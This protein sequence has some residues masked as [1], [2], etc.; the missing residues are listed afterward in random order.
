MPFLHKNCSLCISKL[1][2]LPLTDG[3]ELGGL[4]TSVK[5]DSVD[6]GGLSCRGKSYKENHCLYP[7]DLYPFTRRPMFIIIDSDNSFVF[8][9]IP[10]YFG[11]P[12][13]ILMSPQDVPP[14]FQGMPQ[15]ILHYLYLLITLHFLYQ[16]MCNIMA[17]CSH[18]SCTLRSR[19]SATSATLATCPYITGNAVKPMWIVS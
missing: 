17:R 15:Y 1:L 11:Q 10:R 14:A 13:V 2:N 3:Y 9:H 8:Q 4:A 12:L 6:G 5:R 18:Y 7:G 19:H 16:L